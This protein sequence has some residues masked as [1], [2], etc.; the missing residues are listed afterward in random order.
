MSGYFRALEEISEIRSELNEVKN[1]IMSAA[2]EGR[3][4]GDPLTVSPENGVE[5]WAQE[6]AERVALKKDALVLITG[7]T[8]EGKSTLAM[9]LAMRVA[10]ILRDKWGLKGADW[11]LKDGLAYSSL[12]L[13]RF[14]RRATDSGERGKIAIV[15]EGAQALFSGDNATPEV[16]SLIKAINLV[17]VSGCV[18]FLCVPDLMSIAKAMRVRLAHIWLAVRRRGIARCHVRDRRLAYKPETNFG[19]SISRRCPH[20]V[21]EPFD[22][23]GALWLAYQERKQANLKEYLASAESD[24]ESREGQEFD[25]AARADAERKRAREGMR[26]VRAKR[27]NAHR[28]TPRANT[29]LSERARTRARAKPRARNRNRPLRIGGR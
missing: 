4:F 22:E 16:K 18:V 29:S 8:G 17:R 5:H 23:S 21:W 19:F 9:R 15:D 24:A 28:N 27:R 7:P 3:T 25:P 1:E 12:E 10:E 20:L 26:R 14:Y 11:N 2:A 6:I 13:I